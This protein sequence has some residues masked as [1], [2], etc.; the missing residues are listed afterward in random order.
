MDEVGQPAS[1]SAW[2]VL[3]FGGSTLAEPRRLAQAFK[4]IEAAR[5]RGA[6]AVVV[7]AVGDTTDRLLR[8]SAEAA[9]G[10]GVPSASL[11]EELAQLSA[12]PFA[13]ALEERDSRE[14][15]ALAAR[16]LGSLGRILDAVRELGD[17]SPAVLDQVLAFGELTCVA[18][19]REALRRRGTNALAVDAR[20]WLVTSDHHGE[21]DA[22]WDATRANV[23]ARSPEWL[24]AKLTLHPGFIGATSSGRTTTLGRNGSDYT[25]AL[26]AG[27]LGARELSIWTDVSGV[28]TADPGLVAE[29]KP[30]SR[31]SYREALELAGL[32]LRM[33]HPRTM[34]PLQAA[35]VPMRIR[36]SAAPLD[37]GTLVDQHGSSDEQRAMGVVSLEN[38]ALLSIEGSSRSEELQVG[39]RALSALERA[40]L[41]VAFAAYAQHG[42]GLALAVRR[43]EAASALAAVRSELTSEL[44]RGELVEPTLT[45]P[46]TVLTLVAEAMGR[47]PNVAGRLF[48]A[49]GSIGVNVRAAS[50]GAT[51]RAISCVVDAQDTSVAVRAVHSAFNLAHEQVNVLLLGKGTVGGHLLA[52]L[53]SE[54]ERLRTGYDVDVR[55][56][57]LADRHRQ[58][59]ASSSEATGLDPRSARDLLLASTEAADLETLLDGLARLPVPVLVDCTAADGMEQ[60]YRRAFAKGI[61]VVAANKKPLA[62]PSAERAELFAAARKAHR[63]YRY[64][65]TVGASLPLIET[66]KNLVRTGDRVRLIEGSLSGTLGYL[67]NALSQGA[68]LSAAVREAH[69]LGYTEP[70]PRDDLSGTDAAR[71]AL[72]LARELGFAAEFSDVEVEPFVP[73]ELLLEDDREAFFRALEKQDSAFAEKMRRM[74]AEG[75]TLRYLARVEAPVEPGQRATIRVGPLGVPATHPATRLRGT[76]AFVAFH[77]ERYAEYPLLVQGAGAGG[78]VTAAGVLAD[79]LA[80]S[81]SLRGR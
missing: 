2:E 74:Q 13:D 53:A 36:N 35:S 1:S 10:G 64:E 4:E 21:A 38:M 63:A 51:S 70:H 30:V 25:A 40:R 46:V 79:I 55:L 72:I 29:A 76:E 67:A 71:K 11:V 20:R 49:L 27:A 58:R 57:G 32:G 15:Q 12:R 3:K 61:H 16:E 50:Q 68:A 69:R 18:L 26:L 41:R 47:T 6:V 39:A 81:Q 78:A 19:M 45:E 54:R 37:P 31:L 62:L 65:T 75:R 28:M 22:I 23:E 80:I 77:T 17:C 34:L 33:F 24:A 5:T 56:F 9:K 66:L 43:S 7:S 14:L 52:Q 42:K 44:V 60:V 48:S 59:A 73:R 8:A